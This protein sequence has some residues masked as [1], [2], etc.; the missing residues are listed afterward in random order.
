VWSYILCRKLETETW[1]VCSVA[2]A[3]ALRLNETA[4]TLTLAMMNFGRVPG[5]VLIGHI[6]DT[7]GPRR[8]I[9]GMAIISSVSVYLIWGFAA[10]EPVLLVFSLVFGAFAGR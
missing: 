4:G 1:D 3:N 2:F 10:S 6:S 5:Q 9:L 8:I 7:V